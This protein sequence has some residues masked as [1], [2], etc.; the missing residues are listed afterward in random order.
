MVWPFCNLA[1]R[2]SPP[3]AHKSQRRGAS[4]RLAAIVA[5]ADD[6]II[7]KDL[8]GKITSWNQGGR[9]DLRLHRGRGD[10]PVDPHRHP[11]RPPGGRRRGAPPHQRRGNH[12][13]FRDGPP[14]QGRSADRRVADDLAPEDGR[15]PH[16]RGLE[17]RSRH[18]GAEAARARR[19][20]PRRHRRIERRRDRQQGS[21]RHRRL[22]EPVSGTH[23]RLHGV[24][25]DWPFDSPAHPRGSAQRGRRG[26]RAHPQR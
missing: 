19:P 23:L 2:G 25:D 3:G 20:A 14:A 21:R 22:V 10:R 26:A 13:P 16:H 6:A 1:V 4:L 9:A 17:D 12:R 18:H 11:S 8:T 24:R 7:A 15:R 5:S